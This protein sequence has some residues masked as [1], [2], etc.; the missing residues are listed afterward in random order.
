MKRG[1]YTLRVEKACF[2]V[3]GC[4]RRFAPHFNCGNIS[5]IAKTLFKGEVEKGIEDLNCLSEEVC[6]YLGARFCFIDD[7]QVFGGV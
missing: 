3:G 5:F 4:V 2:C 7:K 1:L 6:T